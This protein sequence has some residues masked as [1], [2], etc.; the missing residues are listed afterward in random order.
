MNSESNFSEILIPASGELIPVNE[1]QV[2]MSVAQAPF[3][4]GS[5]HPFQDSEEVAFAKAPT[6][7]IDLDQDP[8]NSSDSAF[9]SAVDVAPRHYVQGVTM[10][11]RACLITNL[12]GGGSQTLFQPQM[13]W[14]I[15]RNREAALPLR[16]RVLSRRHAVILY[17]PNDGFYLVDL[18]SMN[19]SFLNG[20]RVQQR[21]RLHDGDLLRMGS[22]EFSF[23]ISGNSRSIEPLHP[24]VLARFMNPTTRSEQFIDYSEL[25]EPEILFSTTRES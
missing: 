13:V 6:L 11:Q 20:A 25:E 16:D 14:T 8:E 12:I 3:E 9:R 15:G 17:L 19:G 24:E 18:N 5:S 10:G 23:F 4:S 21:Q 1:P 7:M 22:I 2:E